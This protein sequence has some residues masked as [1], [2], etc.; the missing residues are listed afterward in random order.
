[1]MYIQLKTF[2]AVCFGLFV[3]LESSLATTNGRK[4]GNSQAEADS[5]I[6]LLQF[7][8]CELCR[9]TVAW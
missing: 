4:Y 5:C 2:V 8:F 6:L 1:M 3:V 7:I 9:L